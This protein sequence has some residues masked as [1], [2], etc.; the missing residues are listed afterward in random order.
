MMKSKSKSR[1]RSASRASKKMMKMKSKSRS[2]SASKKAMKRRS[3][4]RSRSASKKS[5]K[6]RSRSKKGGKYAAFRAK[7]YKT[8]K[9]QMPN[10]TMKELNA[11]VRK[12]Y[13]GRTPSKS[14]VRRVR[15]AK[16]SGSKKSKRSSSKKVRRVRKVKRV[17][18]KKRSPNA[19]IKFATKYRAAKAKSM[20]GATPK[21]V[22]AALGADWRKGVRSY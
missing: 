11:A 20:P 15:K 13:L 2:R 10:A 12:M 21:E 22:M 7:T 9:A 14:P 17:G 3:K 8:L 4:S 19:Y 6:S 18:S 1:S 16:R 5:R